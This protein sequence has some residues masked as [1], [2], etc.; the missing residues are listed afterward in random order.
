MKN[1]VFAL[2]FVFS[3]LNAA[4]ATELRDI[5][6]VEIRQSDIG[7]PAPVPAAVAPPLLPLNAKNI[8]PATLANNPLIVVHA[9][10]AFDGE[11]SAASGIDAVVAQ[12][13]AQKRPVIYLL[14]DQSPQGYSDW[15]P[16]NRS[17]NYE[18]FSA[19]GEH[20]LPLSGGEVTIVGGFFGSYD[21]ARG[22]QTL[23]TRDAI[24]MHFEVSDRP[25][26][27]FMPLRAIYFYDE[28]DSMREKLLALSPK[29]SSPAEVQKVFDRFAELFFLTDNFPTS[30]GD[31][32]G[33][34]HPFTEQ[35]LNPAYR[36]GEPVDTASYAFE[37]FFDDIMVS[38]FG[39]GPRNVSLRL[40][41]GK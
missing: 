35:E 33:F 1:P 11:A 38:K 12:F 16:G 39:S 26:T 13:K 24:R 21:T 4:I 7:I 20:N 8:L 5:S 2:V 27:V 34:G 41:N 30:T 40:Y 14:H 15:Y 28:D 17:P 22:C 3:F 6:V 10:R 19:G 32:T 18:L 31:A 25:F 36:M 23:A 29:T 9:S 37:L